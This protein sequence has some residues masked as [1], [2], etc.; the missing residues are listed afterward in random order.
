ME[1]KH[2]MLSQSCTLAC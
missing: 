1:T 2:S